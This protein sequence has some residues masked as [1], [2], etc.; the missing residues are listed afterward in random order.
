MPYPRH[1]RS[2]YHRQR[3]RVIGTHCTKSEPAATRHRTPETA[4]GNDPHPREHA[5]GRIVLRHR[6]RPGHR[7]GRGRAKLSESFTLWVPKDWVILWCAGLG[8]LIVLS[9]LAGLRAIRHESV[10][11]MP[12]LAQTRTSPPRSDPWRRWTVS[13]RNPRGSTQKPNRGGPDTNAQPEQRDPPAEDRAE[14]HDGDNE[15]APERPDTLWR[16]ET[17]RTSPVDH[18]GILL[19]GGPRIDLLG[20]DLDV[21]KTP[22]GHRRRQPEHPSAGTSCAVNQ[23]TGVTTR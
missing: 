19:V 16:E 11:P 18:L 17:D 21:E 10:P 12:D 2:G 3:F 4:G 8:L 23:Y 1:H 22:S 7:S 15:R 6:E 20:D 9:P 13:E 5:S 14:A